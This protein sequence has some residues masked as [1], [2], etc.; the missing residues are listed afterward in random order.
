MERKR[1]IRRRWLRRLGG[2]PRW[3]RGSR[4][5]GGEGEEAAEVLREKAAR[6]LRVTEE[7]VSEGKGRGED[8][9]IKGD[10]ASAASW[11]HLLIFYMFNKRA[12]HQNCQNDGLGSLRFSEIPSVNLKSL[13]NTMFFSMLQHK[14]KW[15][16]LVSE[17]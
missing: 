13:Y 16:Q 3:A 12:G 8:A 14:V 7:E 11:P 9:R 4:R 15:T 2:R 6:V 1:K 10:V 17:R 5:L